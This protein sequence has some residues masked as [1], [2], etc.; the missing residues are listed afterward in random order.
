MQY[1]DSFEIIVREHYEPLFRFAMTLTGVEADARDLTQQTFYVWAT[2]GY[3]LR[4]VSKIKTWLFTTLNR[5]F[6]TGQ[7]RRVRFPHHNLEDVLQ[8]LPAPSPELIDQTDCSQVM[9]ALAK[10]DEV[11][12]E[13]V[14]LYYLEDHSYKDIAVV[15]GVPIGTVKSRI[16]RGIA[17]LRDLFY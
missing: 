9:P 12:Q 8:E 14:A 2:K 16:A 5:A 10:V 7:K 6:M 13:A 3:Q 4:D 17:Q 11:Y 15:L 1:A